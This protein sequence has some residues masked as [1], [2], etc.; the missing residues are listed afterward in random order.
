MPFAT[1]SKS[2]GFS[3]SEDII[4]K[5]KVLISLVLTLVLVTS[6]FAGT[7]TSFAAVNAGSFY[8]LSE[9]GSKEDKLSAVDGYFYTNKQFLYEASSSDNSVFYV[10]ADSKDALPADDA[11]L[12]S[13]SWVAYD[14]ETFTAEDNKWYAFVEKSGEEYGTMSKLLVDK[15]APV[16]NAQLLDQWLKSPEEGHNFYNFNISAN[17]EMQLPTE[18]ASDVNI[19]VE[20]TAVSTKENEEGEEVTFNDAKLYEIR[21][22]Y[23]APGDYYDDKEWSGTTTNELSVTTTGY[24]YFRFYVTDAAGNEAVFENGDNASYYQFGRYVIDTD[25]PE[26]EFTSSQLAVQTSGIAAGSSYTIPT[27]TVTDST[28]TTTTVYNVMKKV[29]GEWVKIYDGETKTVTEGYEDFF[30]SG[31]LYPAA[32]EVSKADDD[33]IYR[34]TYT[35]TDTYGHKTVKDLNILTT[36]PDLGDNT[37]DVW[38]IVLICIACAAAV[39]IIVLLFVKPKDNGKGRPASAQNDTS[40][41]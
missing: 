7:F 1:I 21:I 41:K 39:G 19:L 35:V 8:S 14:S 28:S 20:S 17:D 24:W 11:D 40:K 33:Y 32:S 13:V 38:T 9:S 29:N 15:I 25:A 22:E 12:T 23:C 30:K 16:V 26:V 18:W 36:S 2:D 10:V 34:V 4:V 27:P 37:N 5:S 6:V 3:V 31:V